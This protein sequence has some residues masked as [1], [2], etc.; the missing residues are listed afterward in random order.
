MTQGPGKSIRLQGVR[1][2][3]GE[4]TSIDGI[5]LD[6]PAG[7]F[8][9]ILGPSGCGKST[10]LRIIAGLEAVTEGRV[11][12]DGKDVTHLPPAKRHLAMVF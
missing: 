1:K 6:I 9:A 3:W 7:K 11:E 4:T 10:T 8:T 12:I 5:D 2:V